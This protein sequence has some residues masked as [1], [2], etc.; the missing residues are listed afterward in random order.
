M[1]ESKIITCKS[2]DSFAVN[3]EKISIPSNTTEKAVK[4]LP[5][6]LNYLLKENNGKCSN[7][8]NYDSQLEDLV[9]KCVTYCYLGDCTYP[10]SKI[11]TNTDIFIKMGSEQSKKPTAKNLIFIIVGIIL[12]L[13]AVFAYYLYVYKG[14][15]KLK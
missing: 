3:I 8:K 5:E 15:V 4:L 2:D 13:G 11:T 6:C 1:S 7:D 9:N 12:F 10:P 14:K